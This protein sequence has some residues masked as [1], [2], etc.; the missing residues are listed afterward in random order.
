LLTS[1]DEVRKELADHILRPVQWTSSVVEMI[2]RGSAEFL[3]IGPGQV[4]SGLIRRISQEVQVI[5]LND[6][7]L[8]RKPIAPNL[9]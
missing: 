9:G 6:R 5:T 7:E 8:A 3:E 1:A 2:T 4:L